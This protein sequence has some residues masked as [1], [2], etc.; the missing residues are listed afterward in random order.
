M[1]NLHEVL[2]LD[3]KEGKPPS[4]NYL[5]S[6][7][8]IGLFEKSIGV[9]HEQEITRCVVEN[10]N[11]INSVFEDESFSDRTRIAAFKVF[12]SIFQKTLENYKLPENVQNKEL[13]NVSYS[14]HNEVSQISAFMRHEFNSYLKN[15]HES[16]ESVNLP[17]GK[18]VLDFLVME[19]YGLNEST[20]SDFKEREMKEIFENMFYNNLDFS[21][22][23][24]SFSKLESMEYLPDRKNRYHNQNINIY[25]DILDNIGLDGNVMYKSHK[26]NTKKNNELDS[27]ASSVNSISSLY[28]Y[29]KEAPEYLFNNHGIRIFERYEDEL[30]KDQYEMKDKQVP[31]GIA[32]NPLADHNGAF[33]NDISV[34]SGINNQMKSENG[35]LR[36]IE[37]SNQKNLVRKLA[38]FHNMYGNQN[39]ISFSIFGGHGSGHAIYLGKEKFFND[40]G[41]F[42]K[43]GEKDLK[44]S[45]F[46]KITQKYFN[47]DANH[48]LNS[49]A[50]GASFG[51]ILS[52]RVPGSVF[53]STKSTTGINNP[54]IISSANGLN[55]RVVMEEHKSQGDSIFSIFSSRNHNDKIT[56]RELKGGKVVKDLNKVNFPKE[57]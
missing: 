32:I 24:N 8:K 44:T 45:E 5:E 40:K 4:P 46:I 41:Y 31:Y 20:E 6:L 25:K 37:V 11:H 22:V 16:D 23:N 56:N 36:V 27:L 55:L 52:E 3:N 51:E 39:K 1:E 14:F 42:P 50:G 33:M 7:K 17:Y 9:S 43:I 15:K 53:G 49:C 29:N 12:S 54:E 34:F 35:V 47:K 21:S 48:I 57:L 19:S 38:H 28:S 13:S 26:H 30:L 2:N 10:Q 18:E